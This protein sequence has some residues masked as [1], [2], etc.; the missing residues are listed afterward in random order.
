[1]IKVLHVTTGL[2]IGGAEMML[3]KLLSN[4]NQTEYESEVVCLT[5]N[6][7]IGDRISSLGI[8]VHT[9]NMKGGI[10]TPSGVVEL[11]KLI[12]RF[13]P[14]VV[15]T[16][17]YHADLFGGVIAK[18]ALR[19]SKIVWNIRQ[20]DLEYRNLKLH[21]YITAKLSAW[22]SPWLPDVILTNSFKAQDNH[23]AGGY[24]LKKFKVIPNGFDIEVFK[25]KKAPHGNLYEELGLDKTTRIVGTVGRFHHQKDFNNFIKASKLVNEEFNDVKFCMCG[26][27]VDK[28]NK[29]LM[30]WIDD[31]DL[32]DSIYL[33]GPRSDIFNIL[34]DFDIFV[35]SSSCGEA[36]GNVI[37]EAMACAVPCVVTDIGDSAIIVGDTGKVVQGENSMLLA[38]AIQELLELPEKD[39]ISQGERARQRIVDNYSISHIASSYG[40]F[41]QE[42]LK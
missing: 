39:L 1:M 29:E 26:T 31:A 38:N 42:L 5:S 11:V 33:L 22:L 28:N 12:K 15:Q 23:V 21:T 19:K 25:P 6:D 20:G 41:Y 34:Q 7:V 14:D 30:S 8:K 18:L 35:S 40:A 24:Q 37:G 13:K 2:G 16:W 3:F 10:L 27:N 9:L 4:M 36:F 32:M 17:M